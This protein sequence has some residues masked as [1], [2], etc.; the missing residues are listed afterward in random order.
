MSIK[1]EIP[2]SKPAAEGPL[3]KPASAQNETPVPA[4]EVQWH[5]E[6]PLTIDDPTMVLETSQLESLAFSSEIC[7]ALKDDNLQ[8]LILSV[9]SSP[10]PESELAKAMET[11]AF[12][13]FADKILSIVGPLP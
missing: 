6:R 3:A 2:C 1:A 10:D 11:D 4:G 8:K 13:I 5:A 9:D 12:R 7:D